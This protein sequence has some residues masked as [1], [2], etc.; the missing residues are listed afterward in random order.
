MSQLQKKKITYI[1]SDIDKAL[2]FEW[3]ANHLDNAHFDLSFLLLNA[4]NAHLCRYLDDRGVYVQHIVCSSKRQ[5]PK[6]WI[7]ILSYLNKTKP[8]IVHCHL[9]QANILGLSAAKFAGVPK[10]LYT[11]HHSDFHFRYFPKGVKWDKLSNRLATH[12][13]APSMAVYEI[14]TQR[15]GVDPP[16]ITL[17]PHGFDWN[18]FRNVP[19]RLVVDLKKKYNPENQ[20]PVIGVI[21]RFTE[22]KGIQYIIPAFKQLLQDYPNALLL[23]FNAQGDYAA[24]IQ[25]QLD[26]L[27]AAS[28]RCV[29]FET[30]LAAVYRLFDV[31]VQVSTDRHIEAFGQ[32]YV[33]ALAAEVPSVFTLAGIATD[34]IVHQENALVVPYKNVDAIYDALLRLLTDDALRIKLKHQGW[35][36]VQDRFSLQQMIDRLEVLYEK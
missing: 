12:I 30:E 7:A 5:W 8:D 33:E 36:S 9:L 6:A 31:F 22:L 16:K 26:Q 13:V 19:N 2:A 28:Y 14:L 18:Y 11:R 15:E 25:R 20:H 29:Q 27:P 4:P 1:I 3:V 35:K 10:R 32:T 21:S 24:E 17:I 34:F 23:L